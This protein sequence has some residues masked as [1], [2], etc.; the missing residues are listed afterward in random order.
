MADVKNEKQPTPD[1]L[2]QFA[3]GYAIPL[4]IESGIK[5]RV[6]DVL[7]ASAPTPLTA[8]QLAQKTGTNARAMRILCNALAGVEVL[9]KD[10]RAQTYALTPESAA[11][12]V[13][14][15]PSFQG[16]IF[17]HISTQ[18]IPKW[19]QL[20]EIVA[21]GKPARAVNDQD[22]GAAFFEQFVEDIFPMSYRAAQA[23]AAA[24]KLAEGR[25]TVKVLDIAAGSGVW[26]IALA[27]ASPRVQ[28]TA[29]DWATVLKVTQRVAQ[30]FGVAERF[31]YIEGDISAVDYG[32]GFDVATLGHILHSEGE[33]RSRQLIRRVSAA[34]KP[35]GTIAIGE[36]VANDDRTGPPN[37]MIFAVNMLVNTDVG[38]TFT[39]REIGN[40]LKE[41][42][43]T[44]V[45]TLDAPGP[46][47]MILATKAK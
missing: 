10:G 32:T 23:L 30:K 24:L 26:G 41:A 5:H 18:L 6:F 21:G 45:R 8:E 29:V 7:D 36:F 31:S 20:D 34:L 17:K 19:L 15:K 12:L 9:A 46:S 39:F 2:M 37:A 25:E 44:D 43:F 3:W 28:V 1:R 16:G 40:W 13:T 38:D 14:A 11:F 42:G 22:A 47:P 35:G 27:Q 33:A 4:M